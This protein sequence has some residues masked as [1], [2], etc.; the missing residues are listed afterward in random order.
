MA[1]SGS[2]EV[3]HTDGGKAFLDEFEEKLACYAQRHRL[4]RPYRKNEQALMQSFHR[5][6]RKECLGWGKYGISERE[7]P[8][9]EVEEY[10]EYYHYERPHLG[11]HM[12]TP[13]PPI[14][15]HLL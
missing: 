11:L 7:Q 10:L 6:L 8:G 14:L 12:R 9:K 4:S 3:L 15:P 13:L 5:T 2:C 1:Y